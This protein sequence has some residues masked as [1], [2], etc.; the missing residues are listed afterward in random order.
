MGSQIQKL[1]QNIEELESTIKMAQEQSEVYRQAALKTRGSSER[2]QLL[3]DLTKKITEVHK[4]CGY[5]TEA[6]PEPK[7]MLK[8]IEVKIEEYLT[9]LDEEEEEKPHMVDSLLRHFETKRRKFVKTERKKAMD[10]RTQ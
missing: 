10:A 1:Q 2:D 3:E 7:H 5:D 8:A 9:F 4:E 6:D